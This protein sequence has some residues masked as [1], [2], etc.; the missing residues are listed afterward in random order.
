MVNINTNYNAY[1]DF[2]NKHKNEIETTGT[3]QADK[4]VKLAVDIQQI[5]NLMK[6]EGVNAVL[7]VVEQLKSQGVAVEGPNVNLSGG[8]ITFKLA[9]INVE[10]SM[11]EGETVETDTQAPAQVSTQAPASSPVVNNATSSRKTTNSSYSFTRSEFKRIIEAIETMSVPTDKTFAT[12]LIK[13]VIGHIPAEVKIKADELE[14][15]SYTF[16]ELHEIDDETRGYYDENHE[17]TE[18][19]FLKGLS[20]EYGISEN[21]I[22]AAWKAVCEV[23]DTVDPRIVYHTSSPHP[24]VPGGIMYGY[25]IAQEDAD[26]YINL[27]RDRIEAIIPGA[28]SVSEAYSSPL[29]NPNL[30]PE[31]IDKIMEENY[32]ARVE[33]AKSGL[34]ETSG[35]ELPEWRLGMSPL[36]I[37]NVAL[38]IYPLDP[39]GNDKGE[40]LENKSVIT[41]LGDVNSENFEEVLL[42]DLSVLFDIFGITLLDEDKKAFVEAVRSGNQEAFD[43]LVAE[44]LNDSE[45]FASC[46]ETPFVTIVDD[47]TDKRNNNEEKISQRARFLIGYSSVLSKYFIDYPE[48]QGKERNSE[49]T[50]NAVAQ[51]IQ[52]SRVTKVN[53]LYLDVMQKRED[54]ITK[55]RNSLFLE[56]NTTMDELYRILGGVYTAV[57]NQIEP[58][59]MSA[60][61]DAYSAFGTHLITTEERCEKAFN[62]LQIDKTQIDDIVENNA[63][64]NMLFPPTVVDIDINNGVYVDEKN[65]PGSGKL[66][67][68]IATFTN[69]FNNLLNN[70]DINPENEDDIKM[71]IEL[72][73]DAVQNEMGDIS[74]WKRVVYS[75]DLPNIL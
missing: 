45:Y 59:D 75:Q 62:E 36:R 14:L 71:L 39:F 1:V 52:A 32:Q 25:K 5:Y 53:D 33:T 13:E 29:D 54:I 44:L 19:N 50:V 66:Y 69:I 40:M 72:L 17:W 9:N 35:G 42:T 65:V 70:Y 8:T 58:Y 60:N 6:N 37:S 30:T 21:D 31:E 61:R 11:A 51:Y 48:F 7:A 56:S 18:V 38:P 28:N 12:T 15:D 55:M 4:D 63:I 47:F 22:R 46:M 68:E 20:E 67:G 16:V 2:Y 24:N 34:E 23:L 74:H 73:R 41:N 64:V 3:V 10:L 27:M 43:S 57:A 26:Y 49:K